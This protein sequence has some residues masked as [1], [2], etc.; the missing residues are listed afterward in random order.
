MRS[1]AFVLTIQPYPLYFESEKPKEASS[2]K[3]EMIW[4]I[5]NKCSGDKVLFEDIETDDPAAYIETRF[6]GY[7]ISAGRP[8]ED[9]S[10]T[11]DILSGNIFQKVTLTAI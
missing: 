10:V 6:K 8:A 1:T 3:Y 7:D 2:M 11:F 5:F 9:G 4:E